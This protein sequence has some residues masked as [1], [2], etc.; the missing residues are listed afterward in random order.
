[1][2]HLLLA[3]AM[4]FACGSLHQPAQ[5]G[6][7]IDIKHEKLLYPVVRV[8][9][10]R[11]GGSGVVIYSEAREEGP[12]RTYILTNQHV[13]DDAVRVTRSWDNLLQ[14]Y[15]TREK[16]ELVDVEIFSWHNGKIIDRKTVKAAVIAHSADHD[17][18]VL[19]LRT[20]EEPYPIPVENRARLAND[21]EFKNLRVFQEIYAVGCSLGHDPIHSKGDISDLSDLIEGKT[22]IMGS[23]PIIFGN[24]GGGVFTQI[25]GNWILIGMPARV[26]VAWGAV[27]HMNWFVPQSRISQFLRGQKLTFFFNKDQTP[28]ECFKKREQERKGQEK[29]GSNRLNYRLRPPPSDDQ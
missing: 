21:T 4:L 24:S 16:N 9:T 6:D 22:Y 13:I 7:D 20:G 25:D 27:S 19:E 8:R 11:A 2:R 12:H 17:I 23:A 3:V 1:M 5:A 10:P 14:K 28:E 26:A 29:E 18:A 15:V